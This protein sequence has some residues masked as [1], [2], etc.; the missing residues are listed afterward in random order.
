MLYQT[1]CHT[2]TLITAIF[3]FLS[4]VSSVPFIQKKA[5]LEVAPLKLDTSPIT[6]TLPILVKAPLILRHKP[7]TVNGSSLSASAPKL[8][9][10]VFKAET[11]FSAW[12]DVSSTLKPT[13][14][15]EAFKA[16]VDVICALLVCVLEEEKTEPSRTSVGLLSVVAWRSFL[17]RGGITSSS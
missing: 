17:T 2:E 9:S 16:E 14:V 3:S 1:L 12:F 7:A 4:E 11:P 13:H 8:E 6:E 15:K 10:E 5:P